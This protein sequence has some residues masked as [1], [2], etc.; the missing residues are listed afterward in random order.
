MRPTADWTYTVRLFADPGLTD[1]GWDALTDAIDGEPLE[2]IIEVA[3]R[4]FL[5]AK[6][7]L[8]RDH[9]WAEPMARAEV[10]LAVEGALCPDPALHRAHTVQSAVRAAQEPTAPVHWHPEGLTAGCA[11]C[12]PVSP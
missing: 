7:P 12:F 8:P 1:R 4:Q 5:E 11:V 2:D 6:F 3:I 9:D 10:A